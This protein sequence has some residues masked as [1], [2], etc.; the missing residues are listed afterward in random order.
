[1][2]KSSPTRSHRRPSEIP[3]QRAPQ[4]FPSTSQASLL[5]DPPTPDLNPDRTFPFSDLFI[6]SH[7]PPASSLSDLNLPSFPVCTLRIEETLTLRNG[8]LSGQSR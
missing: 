8:S 4:P 6:P 5:P 1:M 2:K 7:A 3:A